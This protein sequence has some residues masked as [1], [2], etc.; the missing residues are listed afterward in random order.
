MTEIF[1]LVSCTLESFQ[2]AMF[3][4][5]QLM[6]PIPLWRK[7]RIQRNLHC[8]G[9]LDVRVPPSAVIQISQSRVSKELAGK[10]CTYNFALRGERDQICAEPWRQ[11]TPLMG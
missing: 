9:R 10:N 7:V 8:N 3:F 6:I 11:K 4:K 5:E 1:F 2:S